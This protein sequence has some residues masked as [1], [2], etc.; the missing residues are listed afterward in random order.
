MQKFIYK[1]KRVANLFSHI[2]PAV[3]RS[4]KRLFGNA[5]SLSSILE[6]EPGLISVTT[7]FMKS[8]RERSSKPIDLGE[9][10]EYYTYDSIGEIALAR[11][12]GFLR[13]GGDIDGM[14][15]LG[16]ILSNYASVVSQKPILD[17]FGLANPLFPY[18]LPSIETKNGVLNLTIKTMEELGF[19]G[20]PENLKSCTGGDFLSHMARARAADPERYSSDDILIQTSATV[21]AATDTTA[22]TLRAIIYY[23]LRNPLVLSRFTAELDAAEPLLSPVITYRESIDTLPYL[24]AVVKEAMRLHPAIGLPLERYVPAGGATIAGKFLPAG[25]TVGM[26]AWVVHRNPDIFTEPDAFVPE[27]W[28][29]SPPDQ[30]K[31]MEKSMFQFGAGARSCVGKYVAQIQTSTLIPQLFRE[32]DVQ[33]E[34]KDKEWEVTARWFVQQVGL[35]VNLVPRRST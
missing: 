5:Y 8:L 33:L 22:I 9:W 17:W 16:A 32:F 10:L 26:S 27:R 2:D 28:I 15:P 29:G 3:H 21:F 14:I 35:V 18:L 31:R 11:R 24:Q 20:P 25:T 30:L 1:K 7:L 23:L 19:S 34:D 6:A 4:K 12:L 13:N